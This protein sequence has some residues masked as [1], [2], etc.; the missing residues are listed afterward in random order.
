MAKDNEKKKKGGGGAIGLLALLALLGGGGYFGLGIGN[1]N[2]GLL[3]NSNP[4]VLPTAQVQDQT[5]DQTQEATVA[6]TEKEEATPAATEL[7]QLV[8]TVQEDKILYNGKAMSLAELETALLSDYKSGLTVRLVDEKAIES[9]YG[10]VS[11][12]LKKLNIPVE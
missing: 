3:P 6:P 4:S 5:K 10:D 2:G 12:L 8:I 7:T 9:V 1:P 11:A